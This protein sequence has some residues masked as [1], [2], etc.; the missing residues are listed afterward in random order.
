VTRKFEINEVGDVELKI[1][2]NHTLLITAADEGVAL[3]VWPK[4][5]DNDGPCWSTWTLYDEMLPDKEAP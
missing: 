2:D 1:D 3:D 4:G 5:D